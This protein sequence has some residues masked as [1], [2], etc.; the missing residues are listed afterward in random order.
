MPNIIALDTSSD[1]ASV[2][3]W[4]QGHAFS[5]TS[6]GFSSH[7]E[8][9]LPMLMQ[10]MKTQNVSIRDFDAIAF[11]CGPGS[12]TGLR[13]ACGIAEGMGFAAE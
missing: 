8:T 1:I 13:T 10:L 7:S 5:Q 12:F 2:T 4:W 9:V 3:L 11:G 6:E